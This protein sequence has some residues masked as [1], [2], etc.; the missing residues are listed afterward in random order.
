MSQ[1]METTLSN[2]CDQIKQCPDCDLSQTRTQAV[3]GAGPDDAQ[4]MFIGEAPG[5][6]EDKSGQPFVGQAGKFLDELLASI[7]LDRASVYITNVVKCR[8][9]ANRDP[10]K[11]EIEACDKWLRRQIEL[12]DPRVIVTLGRF[13]MQK[14]FAAESI[15]R[16][17]GQPRK[18]GDRLIVPMF[19]PAAALHQERFRALIVEDFKRLPEILSTTLQQPAAPQSAAPSEPFVP[20]KPEANTEQGRLF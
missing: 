16:I 17:H 3:P 11:D 7:G 4:I 10:L 8:P 6:Y 9:P 1:T 19:H 18:V 13:S 5:F 20:S 12:I 15:S 2:L 14:F